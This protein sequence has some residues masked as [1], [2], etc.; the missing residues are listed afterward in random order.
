MAITTNTG[1]PLLEQGMQNGDA[2]YNEGGWITD[3]HNQPV[4]LG[5]LATPPATGDGKAYIVGASATGDW[6]GQDGNLTI[7]FNGAW[8]FYAPKEGWWVYNKADAHFYYYD[9][10]SWNKRLTHPCDGEVETLAGPVAQALPLA[11]T[12]PID[13]FAA[14][15]YNTNMT[16]TLTPSGAANTAQ[17]APASN[18]DGWFVCKLHVFGLTVTNPTVDFLF[19]VNDGVAD[20]QMGGPYR[21]QTNLLACEPERTIQ[22][23]PGNS[24]QFRIQASL[25]D[26]LNYSL[27]YATLRRV[28]V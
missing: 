6:A 28:K 25:A 9:G 19:F 24:A 15:K 26:T 21:S 16:V 7:S 23:L 4:I 11:T 22:L 14:V 13:G 12:V 2:A 27:L 20:I 10:V 5:I 8:S 18:Y 17:F 3:F 1:I